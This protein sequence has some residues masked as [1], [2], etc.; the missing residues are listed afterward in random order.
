MPF[1]APPPAGSRIEVRDTPGKIEVR[2][3]PPH[4]ARRW[5]RAAAIIASQCFWLLGTLF[6]AGVAAGL[7]SLEARRG[8]TSIVYC[9]GLAFLFWIVLS[10]DHLTTAWALVWGRRERII[11]TPER[12]DFRL[13]G[14]GTDA[15]PLLRSPLEALSDLAQE[16]DWFAVRGCWDRSEVLSIIPVD[17]SPDGPRAKLYGKAPMFGKLKLFGEH[18]MNQRTE[19]GWQLSPA[20]GEWLLDLLQRWRNGDRIS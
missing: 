19:L 20:E 14:V 8:A 18:W 12:I 1:F 15:S 13:G 9:I 4:G 16:E 11:L 2:L 10:S 6:L 17:A 7:V 5:K 3:P